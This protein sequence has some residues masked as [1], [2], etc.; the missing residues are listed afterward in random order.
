MTVLYHAT[1]LQNAHYIIDSGMLRVSRVKYPTY[2]NFVSFTRSYHFAKSWASTQANQ[3]KTRI[4]FAF[5]RDALKT[6]YRIHQYNY[7]YHLGKQ[8]ERNPEDYEDP[9]DMNAVMSIVNGPNR[10]HVA[11]E[12]I[13]KNVPLK[14]FLSGVFCI[15][16]TDDAD[17]TP[18]SDWCDQN[19]VPFIVDRR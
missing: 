18:I 3:S 7:P 17:T 9:D 13:T 16:G 5:D 2:G 12:I 1:T 8:V 15:P 14:P 4:I 11:E 19:S 10:R 6:R